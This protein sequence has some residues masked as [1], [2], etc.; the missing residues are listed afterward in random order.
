M[1]VKDSVRRVVLP[2]ILLCSFSTV[3]IQAQETV[4]TPKPAAQ[5]SDATDAV[6]Q[7]LSG[8]DKPDAGAA[9]SDKPEVPSVSGAQT[10]VLKDG[11]K[12]P[13]RKN[14]EYED[15]SRPEL[16]TGMKKEIVPLLNLS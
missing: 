2:L 1:R 16:P 5:A 3:A 4:P 7:R 6:Q 15:W 9:P 8:Q 10:R 12:I 14:L 13:E 11:E